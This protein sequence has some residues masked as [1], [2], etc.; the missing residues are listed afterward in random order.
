MNL[1]SGSAIVRTVGAHEPVSGGSI[2][3]KQAAIGSLTPGL[4]NSYAFSF[5]F[6]PE[7]GSNGGGLLTAT[8]DGVGT[9]SYDLTAS[10]K[11]DLNATNYNAF[12]L[13]SPSLFSGDSWQIT[14]DDLTY[15]VSYTEDTGPE[16]PADT[17]GDGIPDDWETLYFGCNTC[18]VWNVDSDAGGGD[19]ADNLAEYVADTDPTNANSVLRI[20]SVA[21]DGSDAVIAWQGGTAAVQYVEILA[22][23]DPA[24]DSWATIFTNDPVTQVNETW[25]NS[26]VTATSRWYRIRAQRP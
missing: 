4:K 23:G 13:W 10:E 19:G 18:A 14:L 22:D 17:D 26:S 7:A 6:D 1:Y 24:G 15:R 25:T 3:Y 16:P 9:G 8:V 21:L 5:S 2:V 11:S 20:N 12:G